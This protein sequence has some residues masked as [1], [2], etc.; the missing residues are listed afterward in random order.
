[1]EEKEKFVR[2]FSAG[3]ALYR[4][5]TSGQPEWLLIKPA[6][7]D[8]WQLPKGEIEEGENTQT[9]AVREVAE[10]TGVTGRVLDKIDTIKIFYRGQEGERIFKNITFFLME[11]RDGQAAVTDESKKEIDEVEWFATRKAIEK[12]TF[13]SEKE[14]LQKAAQMLAHGNQ[15]SLI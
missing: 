13:K 12:L 8:R 9:A 5:T 7:R 4:L 15:G 10:E 3:G 6:G 1:M 11:Y 14:I 2:K